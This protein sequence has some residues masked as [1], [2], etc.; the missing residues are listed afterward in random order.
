MMLLA[1]VCIDIRHFQGFSRE[2][3]PV[4]E[5]CPCISTSSSLIFLLWTLMSLV[6]CPC[7]ICDF[8][9]NSGYILCACSS[10]ICSVLQ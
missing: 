6:L 4:F 5:I 8:L 9:I 2:R 1:E 7:F 3:H 10:G